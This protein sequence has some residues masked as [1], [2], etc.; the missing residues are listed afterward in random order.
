MLLEENIKSQKFVTLMP[1]IYED[2]LRR[3]RSRP[4]SRLARFREEKQNSNTEVVSSSTSDLYL[5][6]DIE[7]LRYLVEV[8]IWSI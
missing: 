7:E 1:F 6:S 2:F 3:P 4:R 5:L 8:T